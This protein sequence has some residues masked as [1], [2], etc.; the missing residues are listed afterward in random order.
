M[1]WFKKK[2]GKK[3]KKVEP[4]KTKAPGIIVVSATVR[5]FDGST[6]LTGISRP[7]TAG[8]SAHV[9]ELLRLSPVVAPVEDQMVV[10]EPSGILYTIRGFLNPN[11]DITLNG[12]K[13]GTFKYND[14]GELVDDKGR[15]V[16]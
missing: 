7:S 11:G 12:E 1:S 5:G 2:E 4:K 15:V 14:K 10:Y 8:L 13:V 16:G 6:I 9:A 3:E